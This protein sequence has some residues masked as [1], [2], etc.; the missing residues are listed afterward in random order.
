MEC[1]QFPIQLTQQV[2][3]FIQSSKSCFVHSLRTQNC[4]VKLSPYPLCRYLF[5]T[6]YMVRAVEI[7]ERKSEEEVK[8]II[9]Q[10]QLQSARVGVMG[11]NLHWLEVS[12]AK[13]K[14]QYI[15]ISSCENTL[16]FTFL[17]ITSSQTIPLLLQFYPS[18]TECRGQLDVNKSMLDV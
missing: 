5:R 9:A 16:V 15:S 8:V 14:L 18:E 1:P 4:V 7:S 13:H 3:W 6:T 17:P 2:Q 12:G 11:E 10:R